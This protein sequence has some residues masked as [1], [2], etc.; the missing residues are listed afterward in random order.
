MMDIQ[1]EREAFESL[2]IKSN[3]HFKYFV[4]SQELGKYIPTGV[5]DNLTDQELLFASITLNTAY[6]FFLGGI[7]TQAVPENNWEEM[8]RCS[9]INAKK[10][11]NQL[12]WA[13]VASLGVGSTKAFE[14][15]K[16][17]K[18]DPSSTDMRQSMIEAAEVG[19]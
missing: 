3:G 13:H 4:F 7:K 2:W 6:L 15:C 10:R 16:Y 11:K 14:V 17:F 19:E 5:Q 18:I 8:Y 1:K 9:I 12:N